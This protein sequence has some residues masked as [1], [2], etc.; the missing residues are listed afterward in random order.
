MKSPKTEMH[1]RVRHY[2]VGRKAKQN[3]MLRPKTKR[4]GAPQSEL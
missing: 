1:P 4:G 3:V 2:T